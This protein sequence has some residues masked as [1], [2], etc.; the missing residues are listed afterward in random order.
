MKPKKLVNV[1]C[2]KM[3]RGQ[4]YLRV[5]EEQIKVARDHFKLQL[6]L[7]NRSPLEALMTPSEPEPFRFAPQTHPQSTS[8]TSYLPPINQET[9]MK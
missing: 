9:F 8:S 5:Q 2:N 3:N 1:N 7:G 6:S 4:E